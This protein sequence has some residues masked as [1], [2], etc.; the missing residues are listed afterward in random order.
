M[1]SA[2]FF[3]VLF[4]ISMQM[5]TIDI[6][7]VMD[8]MHLPDFHGPE[9]L[10][11]A[12]TQTRYPVVRPLTANI[13]YPSS[14]YRSLLELVRNWNPDIPDHP[15]YFTE[16]L[17]HF[18]Y[19]DHRER[20]VAKAYRVAELPFKLY[21]VPELSAVT[22]LWTDSY[23]ETKLRNEFVHVE[24]SDSNH[25]M[26]WNMHGKNSIPDFLPPTKVV[27][28]S[29]TAWRKIARNADLVKSSNSSEHF[30]FM[31]GSQKNDY[32]GQSFIARDLKMFSTNKNNFFISN[33][34]ANK[35]I[36]C[37]FGMR[38][39]VAES[40]FDAGRNMVA[41]IKG[42]KR[43]ILNPP[44]SCSKLAI[45]SESKHPSYRHSVIDWSDLEQAK[46][47]GFDNVDAIETIL[48]AGEVL[49]I[50]SYWFHYIISLE[51]SIQV[52]Q[53]VL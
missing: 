52:L 41:M 12:I 10:S 22:D 21:D 26:Y 40:H 23:L 24:R 7:H 43:Y 29:F 36:Q 49:Y 14:S 32:S 34:Q 5:H 17:Q 38:G 1:A 35:G 25:F 30:Y 28:M 20:Q 8:G 18:N 13:E 51:Y 6:T 44:R 48:K 42:S 50:P 3:G 37:R 4:L 27:K 15:L 2:T 31:T 45:I 47:H 9:I 39:I 46:S 19:S 53:S 16:V 11:S 33:V